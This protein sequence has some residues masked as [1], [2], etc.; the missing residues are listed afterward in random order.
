MLGLGPKSHRGGCLLPP[1]LQRPELRLCQDPGLGLTHH[2]L[3]YGQ[4]LNQYPE[5]FALPSV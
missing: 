3:P 1:L 5:G 4:V 2:L